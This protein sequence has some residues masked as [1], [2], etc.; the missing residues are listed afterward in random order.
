MSVTQETIEDL[1]SRVDRDSLMRDMETFAQRTKLSGTPEELE[2]FRYLESRM[3]EIGYR[4]EL[5]MHDALISLPGACRV[6][7]GNQVLKSITH[8]FSRSG[9]VTAEL[10]DVGGGEPSDFAGRD[11]RGKIVLAQ[12]IANPAVAALARDAGAAGQLHASPHEHLHEMCISPVWGSPAPEDLAKLPST[13]AATVSKADGDGLRQRLASGEKLEVTIEAEADTG[14]RKTPLLVAEMDGPDPDG[15]F[16]MLSGHHDTWYEGVM[17]NGG[18]NASQIEIAR[19]CAGERKHWQRGLRVCFWSGH[20]HGRYSGSSWYVDQYWDDLERRCAAHVNLDSTG[21]INATDLTASATSAELAGLVKAAV[22]AETGQVHGGKRLS[23]NS[24]NSFWGVGIPTTLG[25]VSHQ[26][27]GAGIFRNAL[28]WW[29]HTPHDL[30]DK[31]DP[32]N[33][34]RDTRVALRVVWPLLT[35]RILPLDIPAQL[36]V[37]VRE[38][39]G[40]QS[41]LGDNLKLGALIEAAIACRGAAAGLLRS[42]EGAAE[43]VNRALMRASRLLIPL[44][45]TTGDRFTP[46]PALNQPVWASLEP[47]RALAAAAKGTD[48]AHHLAISAT[49][50]RNRLM[51]ALR[52]ARTVLAGAHVG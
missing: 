15:E 2:S 13:I 22:Q 36:D 37:L 21:G 32:A 52:E 7:A 16:I 44:D 51:S 18:A 4:T 1:P 19:I 25:S 40:M 6:T 46:D 14:W 35:S 28:G 11:L 42:G 41:K 17:D 39:E 24:D 31:I 49:R 23:R 30:L 33:L 12:G 10:V 43:A 29:W 50:A 8:S 48:E 9:R 20:S 26:P 47:V 5:I 27:G 34:V 3:K 38:L 45:Y